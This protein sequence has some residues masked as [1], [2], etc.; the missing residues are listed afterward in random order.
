MACGK[1]ASSTSPN[2]STNTNAGVEGL[3]LKLEQPLLVA[4]GT[5]ARLH[6]VYVFPCPTNALASNVWIRYDSNRFDAMLPRREFRAAL[7]EKRCIG[8]EVSATTGAEQDP[9]YG[10]IAQT[11]EQRMFWLFRRVSPSIHARSIL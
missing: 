10:T 8:L 2:K 11:C 1:L 6:S 5:V 3:L 9:W 4:E 7:F